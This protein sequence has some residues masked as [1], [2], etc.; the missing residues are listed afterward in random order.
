VNSIHFVDLTPR[1]PLDEDACRKKLTTYKAVSIRRAIPP[2]G[3]KGKATWAK[4]NHT[5]ESMTQEEM[6]RQLKK[7]NDFHSPMEKHKLSVTEKKQRLRPFQQHQVTKVIDNLKS[8]EREASFEWTLAQIDQKFQPAPRGKKETTVITVY[9]K[10]APQPNIDPIHLWNMIEKA[11]ADRIKEQ[12]IKDQQ[13]MAQLQN[14][15][16]QETVSVMVSSSK[17][18]KPVKRGGK[19]YHD[20]SSSYTASTGNSGSDSDY[21]S[22]TNTTISSRSARHSRR[23][24]HGGQ[25]SR[26]HSRRREHRKSLIIDDRVP[27]SPLLRL[28][29]PFVPDVPRAV[30]TAEEVAAAYQAGKIDADAERF[31]LD[32]YAAP[33]PRPLVYNEYAD[34]SPL[35]IQYSED[36]YTEELR[37]RDEDRIRRREDLW[38]REEDKR[39]EQNRILRRDE[40]LR[41]E[42]DRIFA[43]DR[44]GP[45]APLPRHLR[46]PSSDGSY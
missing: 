16:Q 34:R 28:Q 23:Y 46:Y 40:I 10:R 31:G 30:H 18:K 41:Q 43:R 39:R 20:D 26:S 37:Q 12:Q 24:N 45:F 33:R 15:P 44:Y 32:R 38:R 4:S 42:E 22:S 6:I 7:L 9:A 2:D 27:T 36:R 25:R 5:E 14:P 21:D 35:H 19:K 8:Q 3:K 17:D 29:P 11:K 13:R 1:A